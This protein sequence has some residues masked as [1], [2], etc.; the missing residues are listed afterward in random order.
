M[1]VSDYRRVTA[2]ASCLAVL[3]PSA[4]YAQSANNGEATT[5]D[6]DTEIVVTAQK[7][8]ENVID[9]PISISVVSSRDLE[10]SGITDFHD[11]SRIAP[12]FTSEVYGDARAGRM[13]IRGVASLQDNPGKQSSVGV[14]L[15]GVFLAR[16]GSVTG[17]LSDIER[18]EILR[19]PQGTLFGGSTAAGLVNIVTK[20]PNLEQ[21][22]GF[23]EGVIGNHDQFEA[24]GRLSVPL[25]PGTLAMSISGYGVSRGGLTENI[26]LDRKV[27][28]ARRIGG[29][30]KL[31]YVSGDFDLL[32]SADY[33]RERSECCAAVF[34]KLAPGANFLGVPLAPIVPADPFDRQAIE[35]RTNT[36]RNN[37]GGVSAEANLDLGG[38]T[39]TS[40]TAWRQWDV[41]PISDVDSTPFRVLDDFDIKQ[42]HRQFS[43]EL[44][45][46]SEPG[47]FVDYVAGLYYF[48]RKSDDLEILQ[49][50]QDAA[51]FIIPGMR[52]DTTIESHLDDKT[53]AAFAHANMHIS[54]SFT[55]SGGLRYSREVQDVVFTQTSGNFAFATLG[56]RRQKSKEGQL[57]WLVNARYE[58]KDALSTY[59]SV[60]KG[61]KPGGF[62]LTRLSNFND[63]AFDAETNINYEIGLKGEAFDRMLRF[64]SALFLTDYSNFQ[65][66]FFD[67][68]NL[69][70]RNAERFRTK[71]GE[72]E[73]TFL[74]A[75]G[76]TFD[77]SASY[78]DARYVTFSDGGC[79]PG[80][81]S[82]CPLSGRRLALAPRLTIN[83]AVDLRTPLFNQIIG[84]IRF[85]GE[86]KSTIFYQQNLNP[87]AMQGPRNIFNL[88][89]GI[90]TGT[91]MVEV[92]ARNLFQEKYVNFVYP[93]PLA[94]GAY[95]GYIGAPRQIGVR[96][97]YSF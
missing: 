49:V 63:F 95:V 42:R 92:F 6:D 61:Y 60:A 40:V 2:M 18:V 64:N 78:V 69:V 36:N 82:P 33:Q 13:T 83:A 62:D 71:G 8:E 51:A 45:L 26:T 32:I 67:G 4:I 70:T 34:V 19:G 66:Q 57:T 72:I 5:R 44:R 21:V 30:A 35:N 25:E 23:A 17:E 16:P 76:L 88:R 87:F 80:Q 93:S 52:G 86:H 59:A 56:T 24:R 1:N 7:R 53:Y 84:H 58:I 29:R 46:N 12:G 38:T 28:N 22:E 43:Q 94:R 68:L 50:G 10:R 81:P 20:K 90:E 73:L 74:P 39:L 96:A 31:Y 47:R 75:K 41:H 3:S 37:G 9:V 97:R 55:V 91:F 65:A 14:F 27:D 48:V 79:L 15:D 77:L 54:P 89:A 11:L 85:E